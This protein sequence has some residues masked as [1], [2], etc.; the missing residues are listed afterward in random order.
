[1]ALDFFFEH[2]HLC[3]ELFPA[4]FLPI[5]KSAYR[6]LA[7]GPFGLTVVTRSD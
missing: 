5:D 2:R 3:R 6:F 7:A 1:M 4:G